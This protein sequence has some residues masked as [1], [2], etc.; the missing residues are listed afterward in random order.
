MLSLF[1]LAA[2]PPEQQTS[3]LPVPGTPLINA[4]RAPNNISWGSALSPYGEDTAL[5]PETN[6]PADPDDATGML[7]PDTEG[8]VGGARA[9]G[10]SS[11]VTK[12]ASN[13]PREIALVTGAGR[14]GTHSIAKW[15]N[16]KAG[17]PAV[18]ETAK[19]H[20]V[21]VGWPYA[22]ASYAD[23]GTVVW[24]FYKDQ[25]L[26][27]RGMKFSPV[28]HLMREPLSHISSLES[29]LCPGNWDHSAEEK[30]LDQQSFDYAAMIMDRAHRGQSWLGIKRRNGGSRLELAAAYWLDW[31]NLVSRY[32]SHKQF[33]ETLD[34]HTL[35]SDL[36]KHAGQSPLPKFD[37][38]EASAQHPGG[39]LS[40]P[41]LVEGV[42]EQLASRIMQAAKEWGYGYEE[43]GALWRIADTV[44]NTT[45]YSQHPMWG[46][47]SSA[48]RPRAFAAFDSN[49]SRVWAPYAPAQ[50]RQ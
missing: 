31:N 30:N 27:H 50:P 17:V 28:V 29:C 24:E 11:L 39:Q 35:V 2:T 25:D 47:L 26:K 8:A 13:S 15:L 49:A 21:S 7:R 46:M 43:S 48:L 33:L 18:H 9:G 38:H 32:A 36:G 10:P 40:W 16:D 14:S 44:V 5:V 34:E 3:I 20:H 22:G 6:A 4:T 1:A 42:G 41:Q 45:E 19:N 23:E 12:G 37:V